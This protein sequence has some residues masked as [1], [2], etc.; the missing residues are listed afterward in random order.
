MNEVHRAA[1]LET[2][3]HRGHGA[4]GRSGI[5]HSVSSVPLCFKKCG[6][7]PPVAVSNPPPINRTRGRDLSSD[8]GV[9]EHS[10]EMYANTPG[11]RLLNP[12]RNL[13]HS[14]I[15]SRKRQSGL[16]R[17]RFGRGDSRTRSGHLDAICGSVLAADLRVVQKQ[18]PSAS[19]CPGRVP[20]GVP[21][22]EPF[23]IDLLAKTGRRQFS[24]LALHHHTKSDPQSSHA[25]AAWPSFPGRHVHTAPTFGRA[26]GD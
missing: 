2:Q 5:R 16:D 8:W 6:S 10:V 23:H 12:N 26:R 18:R 1:F 17:Q 11:G 20:A 21:G 3:R 7:V 25:N 4:V 15:A 9:L 13:E 19:G 22:S 24:G 14:T